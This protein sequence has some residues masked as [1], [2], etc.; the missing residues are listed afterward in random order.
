MPNRSHD[1]LAQAERDLGKTK[2]DLDHAYYEWSCFTAQQCAEKAVKAL[3]YHFNGD[4]WGHS[5]TGLLKLLKDKVPIPEI[6]IEYAQLL[7]AYY[8]SS[9]YPNGWYEGKPADYFNEKKAREAYDAT[10]AIFQFVRDT[11]S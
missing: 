6:I 1:W 8:T 9:R 3:I 7:D 11:L 5:V 10:G 4:P 2:L